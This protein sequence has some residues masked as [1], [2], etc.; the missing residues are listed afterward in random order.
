MQR[1][2]NNIFLIPTSSHRK[3]VNTNPFTCVFYLPLAPTPIYS[4]LN[5]IYILLFMYSPVDPPTVYIYLFI[6]V[7]LLFLHKSLLRCVD[8]PRPSIYVNDICR[9]Q[10]PLYICIY[11]IYI[12]ILMVVDDQH[13]AAGICGKH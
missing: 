11:H 4:I 7:S 5:K 8:H 2:I 13:N 10:E 6:H 12:Y 1:Q 3:K 9:C